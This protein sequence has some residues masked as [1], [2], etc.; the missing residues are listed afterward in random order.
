M[1]ELHTDQDMGTE[2]CN[3]LKFDPPFEI[4]HQST[5]LST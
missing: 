2:M 5:L 4:Q 1:T 3:V